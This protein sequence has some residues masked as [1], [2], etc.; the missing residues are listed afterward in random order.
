MLHKWNQTW[1]SSSTP[2]NQAYKAIDK[3]ELRLCFF[4]G[5]I[6]RRFLAQQPNVDT[7]IHEMSHNYF[8]TYL[9]F[10]ER[11]VMKIEAKVLYDLVGKDSSDNFTAQDW[12]TITELHIK[13]ADKPAHHPVN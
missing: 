11:N 7:F 2:D 6:V 13:S 3:A 8:M 9:D 4:I 12:E 1:L 10:L 5:I